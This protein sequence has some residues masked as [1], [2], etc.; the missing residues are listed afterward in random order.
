MS[1][2]YEPA[3]GRRRKSKIKLYGYARRVID[4]YGGC[5]IGVLFDYIKSDNPKNQHWLPLRSTIGTLLRSNPDFYQT[6]KGE[7]R[8]HTK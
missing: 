8:Y 1:K 6:S 2:Y 5:S 7:W 3:F 4:E